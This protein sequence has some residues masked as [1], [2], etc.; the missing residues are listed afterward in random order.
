MGNKPSVCYLRGSYLNPFEGG[1]LRQLKEEFAM[2]LACPKSHRYPLEELAKDFPLIKLNT[3]DFANGLLPRQVGSLPIPNPL[4]VLGR[5]DTLVGWEK[6]LMDFDI[7]HLPEQSFYF[8]YQILKRRKT[9]RKPIVILTQDEINPFWYAGRKG[10][11]NRAHFCRAHADFFIARTERAKQAL[12]LEG[13]S[14]DK[15]AVIGHGV[16][17]DKFKCDATPDSLP[18][19]LSF[20]EKIP[21]G[22]PVILQVGNLKWTK[23][24]YSSLDALAILKK[25]LGFEGCPYLIFAGEGPER[26][27]MNAYIER[28]GLVGKVLMPGNLSHELLPILYQRATFCTLP[29][30]STRKVLEQFGIT[31]LE[32]MATKRAIVSTH[33]GAI[34][35]VL[36]DAG[37]LVQ[38]NDS[39]RLAKAWIQLID[40]T[41]YRNQL[42]EKGYQ[43]VKTHFSGQIIADKIKTVY[44]KVSC[45]IS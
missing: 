4:K 15:I 43:R 38:P 31:L 28:H 37:L 9:G 39:Y 35:E 32:A 12:V 2:T 18:P 1:Y 21:K 7:L 20:L 26:L 44:Q 17:L 13:L 29:S 41:D 11:E 14:P 23:G 24:V 40:N 42:A 5:E 3:V 27:G 36:G 16:D 25:K 19:P 10:L 6:Q 22:A 33:C 30:I 34:D 45:S 8:C